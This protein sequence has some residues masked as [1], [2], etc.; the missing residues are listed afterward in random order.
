[1]ERIHISKLSKT[2]PLRSAVVLFPSILTLHFISYN[3]KRNAYL[4]V[5]GSQTGARETE[6]QPG[7]FSVFL[8]LFASQ[9]P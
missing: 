4:C 1:M 8:H 3:T 5:W 7:Q 2:L 9:P 6:L